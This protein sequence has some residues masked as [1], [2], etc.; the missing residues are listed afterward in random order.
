MRSTSVTR[1]TLFG[2]ELA[3]NE[4]SVGYEQRRGRCYELAAY[5]QVWGTAPTGTLLLHGSMHGPDADH[6]RI[7]HAVLELPDGSTWEPIL[8][9]VYPPGVWAAYA[10]WQ[11]ERQYSRRQTQR[12]LVLTGHYGRWHESPHP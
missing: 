10:R 3:N 6:E 8:G 11:T 4:P 12:Q 7:G 9:D 5:T 2:S 1:R